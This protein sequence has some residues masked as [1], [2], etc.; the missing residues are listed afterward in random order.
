MLKIAICDDEEK[1][2]EKYTR[3]LKEM[4]NKHQVA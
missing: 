3:L 2:I 4:A 1:S